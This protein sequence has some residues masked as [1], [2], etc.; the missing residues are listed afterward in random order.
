ME[1]VE[2]IE[3]IEKPYKNAV[4]TI[5]NFDGVHIGHQALFHEVI[6]KAD[7]I[8]GTAVAMTFEPHPLRVLKNNGTP[9]LI[10]L[11]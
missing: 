9:P 11:Y 2:G 1:L 7:E 4:I 8:D 3:N 10:T 5:G 6:E